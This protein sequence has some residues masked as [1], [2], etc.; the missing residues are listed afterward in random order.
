[1]A[2]AVIAG[3][4]ALNPKRTYGASTTPT[5]TQVEGFITDIAAELDTVMAGRG[6]GVPVTTPA[7]FLAYVTHLN[8]LGAAALAERAMFPEQSGAGMTASGTE[9]W[10]QYQAGL[11]YLRDGKLPVS[12]SGSAEPFSWGEQR[13]SAETEPKDTYGWNE[14]KLGKN[15]EF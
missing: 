5:T 2:Y 3:V 11:K 1:M 10:R 12:M 13:Q 4:Q 6:L 14:P 9:L 15:K 7:E 8:E